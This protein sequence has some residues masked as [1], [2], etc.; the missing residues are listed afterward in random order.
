MKGRIHEYWVGG[1]VGGMLTIL[2]RLGQLN[3]L[4]RTESGR[5]WKITVFI[6]T[7]NITNMIM[8]MMIACQSPH[9]D[10]P[11]SLA[12]RRLQIML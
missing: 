12:L 7:E 2:L 3:V 6:E 8:I 9:D 1:C 5:L 4:T 10:Y 11:S